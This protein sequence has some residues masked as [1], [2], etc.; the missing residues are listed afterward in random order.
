MEIYV[1]RPQ[2]CVCPPDMPITLEKK[3]TDGIFISFFE[4][5]INNFGKLESREF[6][7]ELE[8]LESFTIS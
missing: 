5:K 8:N 1:S 4:M 6:K 2:P 7:F 3:K